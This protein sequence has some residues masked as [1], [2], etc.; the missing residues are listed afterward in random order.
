[1]L[2]LF[3]TALGELRASKLAMHESFFRGVEGANVAFNDVLSKAALALM[4][5]SAGEKAELDEELAA[6]LS[7]RE[8]VIGTLLGANEARV[9]RVL[10]R[11]ADLKAREEKRCAGAVTSARVDEHARNRRR[12]AEALAVG[13]ACKQRVELALKGVEG[14]LLAAGSTE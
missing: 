5:A 2:D 14:T 1:M 6:L 4:D 13:G 10:K 8:A 11:E 3:D 12:V 9:A 7:D